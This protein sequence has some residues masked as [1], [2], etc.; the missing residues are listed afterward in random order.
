[1]KSRI[2]YRNLPQLFLQARDALMSHF[3]P[4]LNH[5]GVTDQQWRILRVLDKHGQLEQ[6]EICDMCQILS[7]SMA[8]VL[9]RM[10]ETGLISRT[11]HADDQR[12]VLVRL[13]PAG[14]RLM[15]EMAPLIELQYRHM[16]QAFG[17]QV[18]DDVF[19]ALENFI[20]AGNTPVKAVELPPSRAAREA[21]GRKTGKG[22]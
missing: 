6:W 9:A 22:S 2:V 18:L 14:E 16:E 7:S 20:S 17:T 3:K 12:R 11:R 15:T 8:G 5:F 21:S 1:V 10:E 4:I 13:A 19:N